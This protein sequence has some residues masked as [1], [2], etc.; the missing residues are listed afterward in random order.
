MQSIMVAL[1]GGQPMPN[2]LPVRHLAP[3]GVLLIYTTGTQTVYQR[4]AA[5]LRTTI[6]VY[7]CQTDASY[8]IGISETALRS[9]L[10]APD[11]A[12]SS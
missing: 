10:T 11:L 9:R 1:V 12:D 3:D 2:L 5:L 7:E 6:N 4:L 8:N